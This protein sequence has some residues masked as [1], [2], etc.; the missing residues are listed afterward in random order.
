LEPKYRVFGNISQGFGSTSS[1]G[2]GDSMVNRDL[3]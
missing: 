3:V 2:K 1:V